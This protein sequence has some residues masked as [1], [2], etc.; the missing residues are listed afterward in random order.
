MDE[1]RQS[2]SRVCAPG[3]RARPQGARQGGHQPGQQ[4]QGSESP[5]SPSPPR[6]AS[7]LSTPCL[8]FPSR[9]RLRSAAA[10]RDGDSDSTKGEGSEG[11]FGTGTGSGIPGIVSVLSPLPA[12]GHRAQGLPQPVVATS[13]EVTAI[14]TGS[15]RWLPLT[16]S[17]GDSTG[18][19]PPLHPH[20]PFLEGGPEGAT[21]PTGAGETKGAGDQLR[22]ECPL[23]SAP[24]PRIR[25][26]SSQATRAP[27][28]LF[29]AQAFLR[30]A[31]L[32]AKGGGPPRGRGQ[33][34]CGGLG[35]EVA[36]AG[37]IPGSNLGG[38]GCAPKYPW[39]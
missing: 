28:Q 18:W 19:E 7:P 15:R 14:R 12:A 29:Q 33:V 30:P 6:P 4:P 23:P 3:S 35:R 31:G 24:F 26:P 27:A 17:P 34:V 21:G 32:G 38:A 20:S 11:G 37:C 13:Q 5:Y 2:R 1:S 22:R 8:S 39:E 36:A 9:A 16:A 25:L 10:L